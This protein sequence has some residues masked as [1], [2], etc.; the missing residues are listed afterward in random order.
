MGCRIVSV[1]LQGDDSW[2]NSWMNVIFKSLQKTQKQKQLKKIQETKIILGI[3]TTP[4]VTQI[5]EVSKMT[6]R[7]LGP[8]HKIRSILEIRKNLAPLKS[9]R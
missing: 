6:I 2:M 7:H 4:C 9:M 3:K 8:S 5:H 1:K